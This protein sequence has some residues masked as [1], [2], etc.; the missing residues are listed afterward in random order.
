[1]CVCVRAHVCVRVGKP[2]SSVSYRHHTFKKTNGKEVELKEVGP[3]FEM[4]CKSS[5]PCAEVG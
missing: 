5:T 4:K 3:R 2:P 1:M